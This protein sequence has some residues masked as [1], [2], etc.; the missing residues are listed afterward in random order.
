MQLRP[1]LDAMEAV[2]QALEGRDARR[3]NEVAAN[4]AREK[5][6]SQRDLS[7]LEP[8]LRAANAKIIAGEIQ[9]VDY[10]EFRDPE[11][12]W[13]HTD[14]A[15]D[16]MRHVQKLT[17]LRTALEKVHALRRAEQLAIKFRSED[18]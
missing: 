13:S 18:G 10:H 8:V 16:L 6:F 12:Y 7:A 15:L 1:S 17:E 11:P 2:S 5:V 9:K 3:A 14:E 4:I